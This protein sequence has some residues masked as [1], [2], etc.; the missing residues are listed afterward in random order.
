MKRDMLLKYRGTRSQTEMAQKYNV[1]QQA[2]SGWEQGKFTPSIFIMKKI[3]VDSGIPMERIFF[4][5]FDK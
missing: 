5:I 3:E 2:W 1:S 4:D